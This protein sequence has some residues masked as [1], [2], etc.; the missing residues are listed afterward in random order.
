[1]G[2]GNPQRG[3]IISGPVAAGDP[4]GREVLVVERAAGE[5]R[6]VIELDPSV[7]MMD[8]AHG[9]S[10]NVSRRRKR[11]RPFWPRNLSFSTISSPRDRTC[12]R[13]PITV[14]PS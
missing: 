11:P 9:Y 3:I 5:R 8:L 14:L 6:V 2:H 12:E 1:M 10:R 13:A 4:D 7:W